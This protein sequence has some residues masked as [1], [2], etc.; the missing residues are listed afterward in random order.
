MAMTAKCDQ[1]PNTATHEVA[2]RNGWIDIEVTHDGPHGR[3][4]CAEYSRIFCSWRC[5]GVYATSKA[6]LDKL[7]D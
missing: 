5:L 7:G 4:S 3:E 6:M 2:I 1:C